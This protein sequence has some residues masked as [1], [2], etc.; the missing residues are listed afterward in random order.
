VR[1][2]VVYRSLSVAVADVACFAHARV[3][4]AARTRF[5]SV[6]SAEAKRAGAAAAPSSGGSFSRGGS[7]SRFSDSQT[8][9]LSA[10][11]ARNG[12]PSALQRASLAAAHGLSAAQVKTWL[13]NKRAAGAE[14]AKH[15]A[16]AHAEDDDVAEANKAALR[17]A[18]AADPRPGAD[19][20]HALAARLGMTAP[21]VAEWFRSKRQKQQAK[22]AKQEAAAAAARDE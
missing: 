17:V 6:K 21:H 13:K 7:R 14:K 2:R 10:L 9:A 20:R 15:A 18:F 8:A 12:H 16:S 4:P 19:A 11:L 22:Q 1:R 3:S 5:A